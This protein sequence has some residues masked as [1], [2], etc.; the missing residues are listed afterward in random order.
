[1]NFLTKMLGAPIK[2]ALGGVGELLGKF[3]TDP[4]KKLEAQT[5]LARIEA[6]LQT[7]VME[8]DMEWVKAQADVIKSEANSKSWMARNWRPSL[9]FTFI[10]IIGFNYLVVPIFSLT[11]IPVPTEMWELLKIGMG[12][13]VIGRSAEKIAE[14]IS[15]KK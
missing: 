7:K 6:S 3:I 11:A 4:E 15:L 10:A 14:S 2:D 12:G 9:M 13:Y 8:V 5:E 1:M